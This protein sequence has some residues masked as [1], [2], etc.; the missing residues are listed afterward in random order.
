MY[1]I[2]ANVSILD[3]IWPFFFFTVSTRQLDADLGATR[4][5]EYMLKFY[6]QLRRRYRSRCRCLRHCCCCRCCRRCDR[7]CDRRHIH[8]RTNFDAN[9]CDSNFYWCA[10]KSRMSSNP[11]TL[12]AFIWVCVVANGF[13]CLFTCFISTC[14]TNFFSLPHCFFIKLT[15]NLL[16]LSTCSCVFRCWF[17][18]ENF[19]SEFKCYVQ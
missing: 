15:I 11:S 3:L 1:K 14:Q 16:F 8:I 19:V 5:F 10:Y 4:V 18:V 9:L 12:C 7:C 13:Y 17:C 6:C 2:R